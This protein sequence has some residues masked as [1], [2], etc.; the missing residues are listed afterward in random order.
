[1]HRYRAS[2]IYPW[3]LLWA[4]SLCLVSSSSAD[5]VLTNDGSRIVGTIKRI[6]AGKLILVTDIAGTL[7]IDASKVISRP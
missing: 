1:M 5:I 3:V 7:E 2:G 4:L 6:V